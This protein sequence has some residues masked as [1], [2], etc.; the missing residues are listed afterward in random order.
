MTAIDPKEFFESVLPDRGQILAVP[1]TNALRGFVQDKTTEFLGSGA[2][3][4]LWVEIN[5]PRPHPPGR[6]VGGR[7]Q[8]RSP[9]SRCRATTS[10][11]M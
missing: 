11:S 7:D 10:C 2:F 8:T 3:Q 4:K 6:R 5:T 1:L 9:A